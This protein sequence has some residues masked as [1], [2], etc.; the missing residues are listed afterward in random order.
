MRADWKHV[1]LPDALYIPTRRDP[2]TYPIG[3]FESYS[4]PNGA[5]EDT[6][7]W[8]SSAEERQAF[9]TEKA[10]EWQFLEMGDEGAKAVLELLLAK[11][12]RS[13]DRCRG[14]QLV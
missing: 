1:P 7:F 5:Y 3:Y 9:V 6:C 10:L 12:P 14:E 4:G 13:P 2:R 8:F 11:A